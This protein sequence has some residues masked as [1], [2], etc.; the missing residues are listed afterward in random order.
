VA[1]AEGYYGLAFPVLTPKVAGVVFVRMSDEPVK[2]AL[3]GI[4]LVCCFS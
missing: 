3:L 2:K 1:I 4:N